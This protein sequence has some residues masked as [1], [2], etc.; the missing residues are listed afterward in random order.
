MISLLVG[1]Q[2][3]NWVFSG[4]MFGVYVKYVGSWQAFDR[5]SSA[6]FQPVPGLRL[7]LQVSGTSSASLRLALQCPVPGPAGRP[8]VPTPVPEGTVCNVDRDSG[9]LWSV[10]PAHRHR[11]CTR[12]WRGACVMTSGITRCRKSYAVVSGPRATR[13]DLRHRVTRVRGSQLRGPHWSTY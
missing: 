5:H 6:R 1:S 10:S 3:R 7:A 13:L 12:R 2:A 11:T 9:M 4:V 8:G